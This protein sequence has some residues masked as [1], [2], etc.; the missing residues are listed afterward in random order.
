VAATA[1]IPILA[2]AASAEPPS[3]VFAARAA[4]CGG[5]P[6]ISVSV[7]APAEAIPFITLRIVDAS[8]NA[9]VLEEPLWRSALSVIRVPLGRVNLFGARYVVGA[10]WSA[11]GTQ[12]VV[13][14]ATLILGAE[15]RIVIEWVQRSGSATV[16]HLV[17]ENRGNALLALHHE[18]EVLE[19]LHPL[20]KQL[21]YGE[22]P[23]A[24]NDASRVPNHYLR[25]SAEELEY[26]IRLL[27][28]L[29]LAANLPT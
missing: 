14:R 28:D 21:R 17:V 19:L 7:R 25:R 24:S 2:C 13:Q 27:N 11:G 29:Q 22:R 23:P 20:E 5:E 10:L 1:A 9:T 12:R 8:S 4:V 18:L 15:P 6:C 3:T 16:L 26:R